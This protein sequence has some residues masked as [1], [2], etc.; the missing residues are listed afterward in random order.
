MKPWV[1][2]GGVF[3]D[4]DDEINDKFIDGRMLSS[5]EYDAE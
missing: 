3:D 5:S 1:T 2:P 4:S